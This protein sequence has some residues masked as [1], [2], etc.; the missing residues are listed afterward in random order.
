MKI[1]VTGSD[2]QIGKEVVRL[3]D[4]HETMCVDKKSGRD[5]NDEQTIEDIQHF[6]PEAII[7]L[8]ASFDRLNEPAGFEKTNWEDNI[9]ATWNLVSSVK[10]KQFVF[11]SSYLVYDRPDNAV[12]YEEFPI[13]PR[14]LI[15]ASKLWAEKLIDFTLRESTVSHARIFRVYS[16][17]SHCFINHFAKIKELGGNVNVWDVDG[18][19]DFIHAKDVARSLV[20][21]LDSNAHGVFNVGAG[22]GHTVQDVIDLTAV[23]T[24]KANDS[25]Y[26]ERGYASTGKIKLATGWEPKI[27][28]VEGVSSLLEK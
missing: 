25:S 22:E 20:A 23:D 9:L 16:K 18:K 11:A 28:F 4:S 6:N 24:T 1:L 10:P 12:V 3:L 17:N 21:L 7:H 8:A 15:G 26:I 27:G 14:N 5:L 2:G 19:F 13:K